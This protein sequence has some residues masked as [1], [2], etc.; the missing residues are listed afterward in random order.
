MDVDQSFAG[1][2]PIGESAGDA[3]ASGGASGGGGGGDGS[4]GG[5]S[6]SAAAGASKTRP[7]RSRRHQFDPNYSLIPPSPTSLLPPPSTEAP[8]PPNQSPTDAIDRR[9]VSLPL[10][11]PH[12]SQQQYHYDP[13]QDPAMASG[14]YVSAVPHYPPSIP[15]NSYSANAPFGP[16]E[17]FGQPLNPGGSGAGEDVGGEQFLGQQSMNY[18]Q[19]GYGAPGAVGNHGDGGASFPLG[20]LDPLSGNGAGGFEA[21]LSSYPSGQDGSSVPVPLSNV[22]LS[23]LSTD[24]AAM[25]ASSERA[26]SE[27]N[28]ADPNENLDIFDVGPS[29]SEG[30]Q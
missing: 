22:P 9:V 24:V 4:G 1:M 17:P 7:R 19:G 23:V 28:I 27:A 20:P 16:Y 10:P 15:I 30:E 25:Y 8:V 18:Q 26:P 5:E 2:A 3:G 6:S 12:G 14:S 29:Y 21:H 11:S 13:S